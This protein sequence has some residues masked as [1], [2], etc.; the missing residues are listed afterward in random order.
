[1]DT[2]NLFI[3]GHFE[4][5]HSRERIDVIDP[6]C[7]APLGTVPDADAV[8][9]ERAVAA[10]REA[11]E[12][13]W[14]GAG[15]RERGRVLLALAAA[16]RDRAE[17]LVELEVRN[18]GK[19][20][21]EAEYDIEDAATCF[22]YYAGLTSTI[23]G[24]VLP[25]S[26]AS[27]TLAVR[28][29]VGVAA[30]IIPWN[31]PL[32]MAAWKIA[33]ALCAGCTVVL[34]P[35]EETPLSALAFARSFEDAGVP[36]GVINIVTGR[37]ETTGAAL[38]AHPGVDKIAFTGSG[39]AGR[40]VMTASAQSF[41][42]VSLELGGKS[43]AIIFADAEFEPAIRGALFGVF[44]NQGEVCSAT[45]RILVERSIYP[46]VV[47]AM[48]ERARGIRLGPGL[49]R[50]TRMGPLVSEAHFA[51]VRQFQEAG[52]RDGKLA[53]GGGRASG[54]ALD[55]G[56]FVQPTIFYDV[57]PGASIARDE[58]FG[59]VACVM[60]FDD[61]ED[62]I[63]MANDSPFGLAASVWTRDVFRTLRVV[64][65]LRTGIIWVNQTQPASIEA[66]W[67]GF[68]QSGIGRELGRWGLD[69]YLETKQVHLCADENPIGWPETY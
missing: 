37:G 57:D 60:P 52:K 46:R 67:G 54:G 12:G 30:Q 43:P 55:A 14:R 45:S 17:E 40:A 20:I 3:D 29:P 34:K 49:D 48:V 22:E 38:V 21:V 2:A 7:M 44:M 27:L 63:R 16:L 53:L 59:P 35:A 28:E 11:F 69:S 6:S 39:A 36:P 65:Q 68:K 24:D 33:P 1:M 13:E 15:P 47:E 58:I 4:P 5:A 41:K 50:D 19:P 51:R 56:L 9:V 62:A 64:K 10:A 18:N 32:V 8:D 61:E 25:T 42:R 26:D 31:Y 23:Q 66:P